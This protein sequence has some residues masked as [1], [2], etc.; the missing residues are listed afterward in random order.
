MAGAEEGRFKVFEMF[1]SVVLVE[2]KNANFRAN[3]GLGKNRS[4]WYNVT[5]F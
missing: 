1:V 2:K 4:A 5:I 3:F